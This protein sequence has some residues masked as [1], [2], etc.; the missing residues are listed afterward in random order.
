M[1]STEKQ[2]KKIL[3]IEDSNDILEVTT[4]ILAARGYEPIP[5]NSGREA[6]VQIQQHHPD[7]VICDMFLEDDSGLDICQLM[8][9]NPQTSSIPI[10]LTTGHDNIQEFA[11]KNKQLHQPDAYLCKPF[12]IEDLLEK[13]SVL[14]N[15]QNFNF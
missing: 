14:L 8:K 5:L 9:S 15:Q 7:L 3:I 10:L 6:L 4:R 12:E 11:E 1:T 2:K 13:I